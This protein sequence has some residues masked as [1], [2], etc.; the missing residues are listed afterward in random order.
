[1]NENIMDEQCLSLLFCISL[2][3][4]LH[5]LQDIHDYTHA[6]LKAPL[7]K[8]DR[9]PVFQW[10]MKVYLKEEPEVRVHLYSI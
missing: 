2:N 3:V 4:R 6:S 9:Q 1:M 5:G 7:R 8:R 10:D